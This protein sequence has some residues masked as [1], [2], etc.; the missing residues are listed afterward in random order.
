MITI[1]LGDHQTISISANCNPRINHI[2][3]Q[4]ATSGKSYIDLTA[5]DQSVNFK[6]SHRFFREFK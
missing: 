4:T 3:L 5:G 6:P 2:C 1:L